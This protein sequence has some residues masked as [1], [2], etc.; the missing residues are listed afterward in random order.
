VTSY[1]SYGAESTDLIGELQ[2]G[3]WRG[4]DETARPS[5][6][7]QCVANELSGYYSVRRGVDV[8]AVTRDMTPGCLALLLSAEY[9]RNEPMK[10]TT[11][12]LAVDL[13]AS[14]GRMVA[15]CWDGERFMLE[16]LHRFDN[17]GVSVMESTYW[18]VLRMWS[19][20]KTG[21]QKY[22]SRY[23]S[24]PASISVDTWGV[25]FVLLDGSGRLLGNPYHYRDSRTNGMPERVSAKVPCA[26]LFE[27]T[28]IQMM[29][30]NTLFQLFSMIESQDPKLEIADR[31]LMMP[32]L[33]HY[34]LSGERTNEYTIATTTEML[35][36]RKRTWAVDVLS[37]LGIPPRLL[38]PVVPTE[39]V[40]STLLADVAR[41]C[42]FVDRFPVIA[43]ASH[44]TASA[45]AAIPGLESDNVY[46]SSGTWSLMGIETY[47]PITS[48]EALS[49][50]LTNEGGV[51]GTIR[52]LKN[53]TGLWI[54]QECQRSWRKSKRDYNWKE[55]TDVATTAA[56]LRCLID[57]NAYAFRAP[58]DMPEA[59]RSYCKR[60][61]QKIPADDG[62]VARCCL[63]SLSLEYRRVLEGLQIVTGNKFNKICMV[64][65][66]SQ[67]AL[68][69]QFTADATRRSVIAGPVEAS[70]LGNAMV[71]AIATGHL[72]SI[73]SGRSSI[74]ASCELTTYEPGAAEPWDEAYEKFRK[75][76]EMEARGGT[77]GAG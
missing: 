47:Q 17:S 38:G 1:Y 63:E 67:N 21:L 32:D 52:L 24:G 20:I 49:F 39:T 10:A 27:R 6:R 48:A 30:I 75:L 35:D 33:F 74:A 31:M 66:G 9:D 58:A 22:R 14:S 12:F 15:A 5:T 64:G 18:D 23:P 16:E 26:E 42:G 69:C 43:G 71:Q 70:A 3:S 72:G 57:P 19:E 25:D 53:I 59:I 40:I 36:C 2:N 60:T 50:N 76:P 68:L 54:L 61:G 46:I 73:A 41:E 62:A 7:S 34:W 56:P 45:V 55:V 11:N 13:G 37:R 77:L 51:N 28:G 44:D 8:L 65:G 29:A 4:H